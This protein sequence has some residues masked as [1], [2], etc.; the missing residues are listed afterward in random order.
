LAVYSRPPRASTANMIAAGTVVVE[1]FLSP[2]RL[3]M[4]KKTDDFSAMK[5]QISPY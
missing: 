1:G 2:Q 3:R 5:S 4:S